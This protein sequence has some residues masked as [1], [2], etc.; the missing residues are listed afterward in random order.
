MVMRYVFLTI[1]LIASNSLYAQLVDSVDTYPNGQ[2]R[3]KG[4]IINHKKEG[5]WQYFYPND[6][7]SAVENY[8]DGKLSGEVTYYFPN[9]KLQAVEH[10]TAGAQTDS[11]FYYHM[12]GGLERKG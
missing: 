6:K 9:S 10:W 11:A 5:T 4:K 2:T 12:D 3:G 8:K 7:L 1:F